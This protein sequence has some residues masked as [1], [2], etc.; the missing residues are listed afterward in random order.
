VGIR[1][2][3]ATTWKH[4]LEYLRNQKTLLE[5]VSHKMGINVEELNG[6]VEKLLKENK[7]LKKELNNAQNLSASLK[8]NQQKTK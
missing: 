8:V 3:E 4:S 5:N 1:R 2:I 7:N 6:S